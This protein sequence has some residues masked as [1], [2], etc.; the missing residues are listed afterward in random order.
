MD[1]VIVESPAKAKTINKYLGNSFKV[2][3]S[4]GHIRDL[5]SKDGSVRPDEDFAMS[6]DVERASQKRLKEIADAVKGA[7]HL[8][9]ATDPDREGEAIS[10][11]L[12]EVLKQKRAL[13]DV[14]V[15]RVVFN[16]ITKRAVE[17]GI[18]NPRDI[19]Q[20]LVDA[21][22]ARRAL[23]YLVGFTL[24]PVL[25]RKLPGARSA[26]RVQSVALRLV[27]NRELEI[28]QFN[29]REYWTIEAQMQSAEGN[30]FSTRLVTL[31][32]KKLDRFDL[33]DE[34]AAKQAVG[35]IEKR[36]FHIANVEKKPGKRHPQ[37]PFTTSTLQQ[38][39]ARKLGFGASQTMRLAQT[40]YEGK[41]VDGE[42]TGLI[43]YM[44][45]D[46]VSIAA[47]AIASARKTIASR[48]GEA[49]L[50][51]TPRL[52]K[53]KAKNAQ[54]AHE[55]IRPTDPSLWPQKLR[56]ALND[57]EYK[58]YDL[59]WKRTVASQMQSA[60]VE[61]STIDLAS[62][63]GDV[64]LR[65]TG[66][67]IRFDGY[68]ALYQEGRDDEEDEA[69]AHL[70][71]VQIGEDVKTLAVNPAQHF[72]EP[73]PR[74]TE[75]SLVKKLEEL[76]IGRPSTYASI[77]DVLSARNYVRLEKKRFIPEDK[78]RLVTAFLESFFARYV[79]YD[80]TAKLESQLDDVSAGTAQWKAVLRDFWSAFKPRTDEVLAERNTNILE[81]LNETLGT[82]LFKSEEENADPRQCPACENG[83]LSLKTGRYGAFI[84]CS[85]YPD[86]RYTRQFSDNGSDAAALA[87]SDGPK[88]LGQD[89]ESGA[90]ISLRAGRFGPYLQ[91]GEALEKGEKPPRASIPR[92][93]AIEDIDLP[94]ALKLLSLPRE[95]GMHPESG[96]PVL[97]N[98]GRYGPYVQHEK[99]YGKL[100]STEEVFSVGMNRA[101]AAL[102]ERAKGRAPAKAEIKA[103]GDHPETGKPVRVMDGRYG[104]YVSHDKINATLPKDTDPL[105]LEMD[106]AL[107]ILAAKIAKS[108][109]APAKKAPAK[110]APAKKA[111]AKKAPA[112]TAAKK[113]ATKKP[114]AKKPAV[115]KPAAKK[116]S[117]ASS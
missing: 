16:E 49:Y 114:A 109:Q 79:E 1:V 63:S 90:E 84:G 62:R 82:F 36:A 57:D 42:T 24:S 18:S 111:P 12:L 4:Y 77:L 58:L 101:V 59:I 97:A 43:T 46:G 17:A 113:P 98:I 88:I 75:A 96:K 71:A 10:W 67:V 7:D 39:A 112:K 93:I 78:G 47:E 9:L 81:K 61:R 95:V 69:Q 94:M 38:E 44:R 50:P 21:Y 48:Y 8:Y 23:D 55:A 102:A 92:D 53:S 26:G 83:R 74:F 104:P 30:S 22:L 65:A 106:Q 85:N 20:E 34:A 45:T 25:W 3:A 105:T 54:E 5:P 107:D 64:G 13:K 103:L 70:P 100:S 40:L 41:T 51:G 35:E 6:W 28:E 32:G 73:P 91:K 19:D 76:G 14:I 33:A 108:G 115:K 60:D 27:C 72:T 116:A 68:L 110:K 86:C 15:K 89:P 37:P 29:R 52:Y 87:T 66:T 117:G 80:F 99:T 56:A 31:D 11:H 2:L